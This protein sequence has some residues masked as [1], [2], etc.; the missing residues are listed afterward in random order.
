VKEKVL[1][2]P[3]GPLTLTPRFGRPFSW[4]EK[5]PRKENKSN[6]EKRG[7]QEEPGTEGGCAPAVRSEAEVAESA[8]K[9]IYSSFKLCS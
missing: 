4:K 6:Y 8:E 2:I 7:D 9:E 1:K 3:L 5:E